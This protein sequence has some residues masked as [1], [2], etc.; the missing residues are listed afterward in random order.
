MKAKM[1]QKPAESAQY[2]CIWCDC[3]FPFEQGIL[4]CPNCGN[5]KDLV[6]IHVENNPD[7]Q[8]LYAKDEFHGG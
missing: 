8:M 5:N 1:P 6:A 2:L 4:V 7:E 3:S